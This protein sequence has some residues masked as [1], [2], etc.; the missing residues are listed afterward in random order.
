MNM[1]DGNAVALRLK[2]AKD[3]HDDEL[4]RMAE[5]DRKRLV[6]EYI[7]DEKGKNERALCEWLADCASDPEFLHDMQKLCRYVVPKI[8][9]DDLHIL[10]TAAIRLAVRFYEHIDVHEGD[11]LVNAEANRLAHEN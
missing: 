7:E 8:K 11:D 1:P 6:E 4:M 10:A 3:D 9:H 2:M 5:A